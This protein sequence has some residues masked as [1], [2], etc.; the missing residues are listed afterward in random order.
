LGKRNINKE[1]FSL[2]LVIELLQFLTPAAQEDVE[3]KLVKFFN[4][5]GIEAEIENTDTGN[6]SNA[7]NV[8][9]I[10]TKDCPYPAINK[11]NMPCRHP[12]SKCPYIMTLDKNK[13]CGVACPDT[14][15]IRI[16][17]PTERPAQEGR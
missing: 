11:G 7:F 2:T 17:R 10:P 1:G 6:T 12:H 16:H 8:E 3:D 14:V 13:T 9:K 5:L 15:C 4:D